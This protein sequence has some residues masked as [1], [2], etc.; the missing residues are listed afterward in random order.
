MANTLNLPRRR[1]FLPSNWRLQHWDEVVVWYEQLD[2]RDLGTVQAFEAFLLDRSALESALDEDLAWRYIRMTCN[3]EDDRLKADYEFFIGSIYP[4]MAPWTDRLNRKMLAALPDGFASDPALALWVR[5]VETEIRL[6]RVENIPLITELKQLESRYGAIAGAMSVLFDGQEL[7]MPQAGV[8]LKS[9]DRMIRERIW[10]LIAERR[11]QDAEVLDELMDRL[12]DLRHRIALG[13]GFDSYIP[14]RFLELGRFDYEH[15]DCLAFHNAIEEVVLPVCHR[16]HTDRARRLGLPILR[17]WDTRA[18]PA[19]LKALTPFDSEDQLVERSIRAFG[20]ID[21]YFGDCL[22]TMREMGHFD[23]YSRKG[24]AP[25][26]YNYPLLDTGAPFIFMN[27]AGTMED[28]ETMMHEGG[29]A[30]HSFLTSALPLGAYRQLPSETAELASMSMELLAME[31]FSVFFDDDELVRRA[32]YEQLQ[33]SLSVLPWIAAIDAFQHWTYANPGHSRAER[34]AQWM[35]IATRFGGK[36]VD[37][38]QLEAHLGRQWQAQLHLFEVPFYYI[39]YGF[40]QL[41]ALGVWK[42]SMEAG[43]N[44]LADYKAAL[45]LGQTRSVREVYARAGVEFGAD[46]E[47]IRSLLHFTEAYLE[48]LGY[49]G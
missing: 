24:K 15:A 19:D 48:G 27:A 16:F 45:A 12:I 23:L 44:A 46:P 1:A 2:S 18:E 5:R 7:T 14:Y 42:R 22:H 21:P 25:G 3:T 26:G 47:A 43:S 13:A 39:E 35:E 11:A 10:H 32:R 31:H 49:S 4:E 17:P 34:K 20:A 38:S 29:H 33:R 30:V 36:S 40:A 6:Y 9:P 28:L 8:L 37:W 41:G